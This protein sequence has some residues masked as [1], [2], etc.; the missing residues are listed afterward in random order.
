VGV[1]ELA[2]RRLLDLTAELITYEISASSRRT[3]HPGWTSRIVHASR[4]KDLMVS[5]VLEWERLTGIEKVNCPVC[6]ALPGSHCI[7]CPAG[8]RSDM[9]DLP[10]MYHQERKDRAVIKLGIEA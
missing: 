8:V 4:N 5:R 1:H 2:R 7:V 3:Q 6:W 9:Q 10:E